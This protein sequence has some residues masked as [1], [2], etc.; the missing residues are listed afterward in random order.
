ME[1]TLDTKVIKSLI[2]GYYHYLQ[3]VHGLS[4]G[5]ANSYSASVSAAIRKHAAGPFDQDG[6]LRYARY[7]H[8]ERPS[9]AAPFGT[10]WRRWQLYMAT[11]GHQVPD[12]PGVHVIYTGPPANALWWLFHALP[13]ISYERFVDLRWGQVRTI[14]Q[15]KVEVS[16]LT[17]RNHHAGAVLGSQALEALT[18][19]KNWSFPDQ[20]AVLATTLIMPTKPQG[21]SAIRPAVMKRLI[22]QAHQEVML[23]PQRVVVP[24]RTE[25][26][27]LP[28][29]ERPPSVYVPPD[30][31]KEDPLDKM[32]AEYEARVAQ[33]RAQGV[34]APE[35]P[36]T[37]EEIED[38]RRAEDEMIAYCV[39]PGPSATPAWIERW[40]RVR[41]EYGF[42]NDLGPAPQS[43]SPKVREP[44]GSYRMPTYPIPPPATVPAGLGGTNTPPDAGV[45]FDD[46]VDV[47]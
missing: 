3:E 26:Q 9:Y 41:W 32:F 47:D 4:P 28:K 23:E 38:E 11:Q 29:V 21:T 12:L 22:K 15:G 20:P 16:Y 30:P 24:I 34:I 1:P 8:A 35:D 10:A 44:S 17:R 27:P 18:K 31:P 14:P 6:L 46:P 13:Q 42:A 45:M 19:L 5:A 25:V 2:L 36:R 39:A 40:R 7:L 43:G 37:P 33:M